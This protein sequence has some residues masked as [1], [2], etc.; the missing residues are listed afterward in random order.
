VQSALEP[1]VSA[2]IME[3]HHKK[4]HQTY[5][6]AL[7]AA[8][9]KYAEVGPQCGSW[10][11]EGTSYCLR[12]HTYQVNACAWQ[13]DSKGDVATMIALEGALKFNG[14]GALRRVFLSR[15]CVLPQLKPVAGAGHVNHSIFWTNLV[16][17]KV[18]TLPVPCRDRASQPSW[19]TKPALHPRSA[20]ATG[21]P[22]H[23]NTDQAA[24]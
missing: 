10:P 12:L 2:E 16:P 19:H 21:G 9:E 18:R 13:A 6:T 24:G 1:V 20:T 5:V 4:H 11:L 22:A 17:P 7:N 14:G 23:K 8:A 15:S 3:L